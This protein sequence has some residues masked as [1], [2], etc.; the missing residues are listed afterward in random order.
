MS[1]QHVVVALA[2]DGRGWVDGVEVR[3]GTDTESARAAVLAH[4]GRIAR[5][6]RRP[7]PVSATDPD[8]HRWTFVVTTEGEALEPHEARGLTSDPD[9]QDVPAAYAE[10]A[11]GIR[12]ALDAGREYTGLRLA[13][14]LE[15]QIAKEHG[16]DHPFRLRALELRAHAATVAGLP[17]TGA[18][19]YLEAARGWDTLASPAYWGAAQR[20]YALWHRASEQA[21]R[22]IWLGE[23]LRDVLVLGGERTAEARAVVLRRI[24]ELRLEEPQGNPAGGAAPAPS[25]KGE[26]S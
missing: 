11:A 24:D 25:T 13:A 10:Q 4:V 19:L 17:G 12:A 9:A 14:E 26:Q 6:R 7:V 5:K 23:Q 21:P 1:R 3:G 22:M 16:D 8:G 15:Q 18:E 20:A 2:A